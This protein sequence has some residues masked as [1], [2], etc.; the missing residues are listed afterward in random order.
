MWNQCVEATGRPTSSSTTESSVSAGAVRTG[1]QN[2]K[3][4]RAE[5][6]PSWGVHR[7]LHGHSPGAA[8]RGAAPA[9][10]ARASGPP[11][12][13]WLPGA[14]LPGQT[15][16][17]KRG[18]RADARLSPRPRRRR[19]LGRRVPV[20]LANLAHGGAGSHRSKRRRR[21]DAS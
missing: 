10:D 6:A 3:C 12:V 15:A 11:A 18:A 2:Y 17:G 1:G 13:S 7:R 14:Q 19:S 21:G 5:G 9:W 20:V 4:Q 16:P 8:E